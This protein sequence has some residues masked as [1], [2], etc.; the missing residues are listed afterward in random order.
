MTLPAHWW[1]ERGPFLDALYAVTAGKSGGEAGQDGWRW[2]TE[3]ESLE[4]AS[5]VRGAQGDVLHEWIGEPAHEACRAILDRAVPL[6][7]RGEGADR[8]ARKFHSPTLWGD[9]TRPDQLWIALDESTPPV[10]WIPAGI[11]AASLALA[12]APYALPEQGEALPSILS[13]PKSLRLF[14]GTQ[15]EVKIALDRLSAF[16]QSSPGADSLPWGSRFGDDPWPHHPVGIALMAVGRHMPENTQ[17]ADGA[18][19]TLTMRTRRLGAAISVSDFQSFYV[20]DVLYAPVEHESILA[21]L[22]EALP[23]L[24]AGLPQD[25]PVDALIVIA[26]FHGERAEAL[27]EAA[28]DPDK[29]E[30]LPFFTLAYVAALG[31][32]GGAI[33][34][35][36]RELIA[37]P[38]PEDR[39]IAYQAAAVSQQ[40]RLL[41]EALLRD[42]D[43]ENQKLLQG[44]LKP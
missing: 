41:Y 19:P 31:D 20:I 2:L 38:S 27:R 36:L 44:H 13:L 24:P 15:G 28:A 29:R 10:L 40:T 42:T 23:G 26:H 1:K 16:I 14:I 6:A 18:I 25:I 21:A 7:N 17:Q 37:R 39:R 9:L 3:H 32:D 12:F 22:Y 35:F 11:T 4:L 43:P 30:E 33:R 8:W 5:R 34:S